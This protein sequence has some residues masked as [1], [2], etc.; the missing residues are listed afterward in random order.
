M[1]LKLWG[2]RVDFADSGP[3]GVARA[4]V[5]RPDAALIDIGLPGLNGYEVVQQIR[6][7]GTPW[8]R[9]VKLVALTGYGRDADR[10]RAVAS[11][12]D[13]HFVKPVDPTVLEEMLKE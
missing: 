7:I 9:K 5:N 1:L 3:T 13:Y 2:H 10:D 8:A 12:F 4:G 6:S 11:G